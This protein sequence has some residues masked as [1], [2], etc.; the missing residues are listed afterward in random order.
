MKQVFNSSKGIVVKNVPEPSIKKGFVKIKVAY[1]CI[2]AG[3]ELSSVKGAD[4]NIL[5][6]IIE[7]PGK[8]AKTWDIVKLKD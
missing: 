4:K 8:I 6:K 7:D 1:S 2:S 3:T 5:S